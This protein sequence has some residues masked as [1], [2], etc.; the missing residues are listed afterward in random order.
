MLFTN[1][2]CTKHQDIHDQESFRKLEFRY[3]RT[4]ESNPIL[5]VYLTPS[6]IE[7]SGLLN[8]NKNQRFSWQ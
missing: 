3:S 2:A 5:S 4:P 7:I 8:R 6:E 1:R